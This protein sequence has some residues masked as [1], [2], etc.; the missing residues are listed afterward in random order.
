[1]TEIVQI[2]VDVDLEVSVEAKEEEG[3]M[4]CEL[5]M[6]Y[7]VLV[8]VIVGIEEHKRWRGSAITQTAP[9]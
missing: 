1:M 6:T 7:H 5:W 2:E 9:F 8:M 4:L 3:R